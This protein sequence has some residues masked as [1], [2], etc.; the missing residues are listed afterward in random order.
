[1]SFKFTPQVHQSVLNTL[2]DLKFAYCE[3]NVPQTAAKPQNE[4]KL[5]R[6]PWQP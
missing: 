2:V 3:T 5:G 6:L 4:M 1:M